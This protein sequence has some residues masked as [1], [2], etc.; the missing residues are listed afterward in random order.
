MTAFD[1]A[2]LL[3]GHESRAVTFENPTG[4]RGAGGTARNGR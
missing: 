3:P 4:E 2:D 1:P